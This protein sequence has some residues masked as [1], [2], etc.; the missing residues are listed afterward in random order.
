MRMSEVRVIGGK[1]RSRKITF[2]VLEGVRPTHDRVRETLFNWLMPYI[3]GAVCLDL[4]AGSG[5]LSFEALSRGAAKVVAV[6]QSREIINA[7]NKNAE[8]LGTLDIVAIQGQFPLL[9]LPSRAP[10]DIVFL[11]PPY[12]SRLLQEAIQWIRTENLLCKEGVLYAE[13]PN[14]TKI[15]AFH[16]FLEIIKTKSTQT[17]TYSLFRL[18]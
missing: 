7:I 10:F 9:S 5:A 1:W 6:D 11:D 3:E 4:F 17:L 2:P 18:L 13:Y 15:D 14:E 16:E 12:H 8:R